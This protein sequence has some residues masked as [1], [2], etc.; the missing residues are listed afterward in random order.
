MSLVPVLRISRT[1]PPASRIATRNARASSVRGL[2]ITGGIG[3]FQWTEP[4]VISASASS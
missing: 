1:S 4:V 3:S 2:S